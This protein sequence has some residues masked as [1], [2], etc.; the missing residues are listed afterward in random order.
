MEQ[1]FIPSPT[2][3]HHPALQKIVAD[4]TPYEFVGDVGGAL[5]GPD[6]GA[7]VGEVDDTAVGAEV[8]GMVGAEVGALVGKVVRSLVGE[9]DVADDAQV[10]VHVDTV[11]GTVD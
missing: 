3:A 7:L 6:V 10:G 1:E 8:G 9:S 5:V 4:I 2:A 11:V